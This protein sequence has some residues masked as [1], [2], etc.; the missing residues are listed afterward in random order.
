MAGPDV[1][2]LDRE[3][4]IIHVDGVPK[5][6]VELFSLKHDGTGTVLLADGSILEGQIDLYYCHPKIP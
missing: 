1:Q 4:L 5:G 3:N 2:K 6:I